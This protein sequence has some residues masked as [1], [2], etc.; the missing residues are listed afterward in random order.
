[1]KFV[2]SSCG[3]TYDDASLKW[4]CSCGG[5]LSCDFKTQFRKEDIRQD[6]HNMWRYEGAFPLRYD[7]L[8]VTYN[9]GLTPLID[10]R[11]SKCRL[12]VKMDSLMPTGSFKDRGTVMVINHLMKH[13]A[14]KITE[15]S[16][17][18]AGASV[19]G[20]CALGNIPCE[21]Y[22]PKGNS[23]G[24][25]T[26]I[27]AYGAAIHEIEGTREDVAAAAQV[28]SSSY[29][30]HNWHPMFVQ[31][32]KSLAYELWEQSGFQSPENIVAVA[33]NG[34][35]VL[36]IYYG[37]KELLGNGQV[38]K[39]PRIFAVQSENCNPIYRRYAGIHQDGGFTGTIAEGIALA[40]PNKADQVVTA[41]LETGG[42]VLCV[43]E[44]EIRQAIPAVAGLGV[45]AEPTSCAAFAG[46][47]KLVDR[48]ILGK[49]NNVIMVVSGNGLKAGPEIE[50]L[51]KENR[52]E[53]K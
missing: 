37:F 26:Q 22:V 16:S 4:M 31:G 43:S 12:K 51:T 24:K 41:V 49:E 35:T 7:E 32:T 19:A 53:K 2:C 42:Q 47:R 40:K 38:S 27:R 33:G 9:E 25:L 45:Y 21:I 44:E 11:F 34:S 15:D 29:A 10:V 39:M 30:G 28:H 52:E 46:I 6:R 18:N 1:M 50:E 23:A 17:G 5:C 14:T 20:Y 3:K 8:T 36:G 48:N 13:G